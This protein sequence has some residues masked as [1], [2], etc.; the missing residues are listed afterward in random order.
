MKI[1]VFGNGNISFES[2]LNC[3]KKSITPLLDEDNEFILCDFKG[4]D[5]LT[6][7]LLKTKTA[8][9]IVFHIGKFPRY[10]PDK[11]K[12]KVSQWIYKGGFISDEERDLEAL[13]YCTHF[14]ATDFNSNSKR[15]SGTKKNIEECLK[16][17]KINLSSV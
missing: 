9:V 17:G 12:T 1:F 2:Y 7:E 4:V 6:A 5:T 16:Q 11:Y 8:N 3:Y 14:I 13:N 10:T 15:I